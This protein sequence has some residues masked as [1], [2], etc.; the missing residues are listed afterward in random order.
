MDF[1]ERG[2]TRTRH[3]D[4]EDCWLLQGLP[5]ECFLE[6]SS[7]N[8]LVILLCLAFP[9]PCLLPPAWSLP[10]LTETD[11]LQATD[12]PFVLSSVKTFTGGSTH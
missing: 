9:L 12:I 11:S 5:P 10:S 4:V 3:T 7:F 1:I 2:W 8:L 6:Y